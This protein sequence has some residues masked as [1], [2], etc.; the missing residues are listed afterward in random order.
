MEEMT[1]KLISFDIE[2]EKY[3]SEIVRS[4]ILEDFSN[5]SIWIG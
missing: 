4:V 5:S 3:F 1:E 2:F